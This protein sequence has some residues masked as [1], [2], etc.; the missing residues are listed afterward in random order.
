MIPLNL[1]LPGFVPHGLHLILAQR[2]RSHDCSSFLKCFLHVWVFCLC[3][4]TRSVQCC[5]FCCDLALTFAAFT[6]KC[7][8]VISRRLITAD[9]AELILP[10]PAER[11]RWSGPLYARESILLIVNNHV[12]GLTRFT[13]IKS[14]PTATTVVWIQAVCAEMAL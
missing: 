9:H 8:V 3:V 4:H 12:S 13:S 14:T 1:L 10:L 11:T 5:L 2:P 7:V 6:S